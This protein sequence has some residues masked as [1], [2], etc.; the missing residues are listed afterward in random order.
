MLKLLLHSQKATGAHEAANEIAAV[1]LKPTMRIGWLMRS[2][3]QRSSQE[4]PAVKKESKD[5]DQAHER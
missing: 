3:R 5:L 1:L 4:N 2:M